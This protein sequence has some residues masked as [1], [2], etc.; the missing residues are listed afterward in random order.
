MRYEHT[1]NVIELKMEMAEIKK[2]LHKLYDQSV[3]PKLVVE[4]VMPTIHVSNI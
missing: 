2:I 4:T 3:I 1:P